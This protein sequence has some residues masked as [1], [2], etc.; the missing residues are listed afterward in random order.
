MKTDFTSFCQPTRLITCAKQWQEQQVCL[1]AQEVK[2]VN[3]EVKN[4]HVILL[5]KNR[6]HAI[7]VISEQISVGLSHRRQ[8][9]LHAQHDVTSLM[10]VCSSQQGDVANIVRANASKRI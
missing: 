4:P 3:N 5:S 7:S 6:P 1:F 2:T 10:T 8:L 9:G